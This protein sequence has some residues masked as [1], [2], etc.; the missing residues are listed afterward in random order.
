MKKSNIAKD[1]T[2]SKGTELDNKRIILCV[3]GSVAAYRAIELARLLIRHGAD[4]TCVLSAAAIR[5][6]KPE[7]FRWATG[8]T[9]ITKLTG[10][11]EHIELA[12]YN[13]SDLIIIYPA[14]ANT[15]GK[16]AGGIDDTP[17]STVL[18]VALGSGIPIVA[19]MAM[20]ASMHSNPAVRRNIKFL[21]TH[22][23]F[24]EPTITEG[25]AKAPEPN[26]VLD[27][28]IKR[29]SKYSV[30]AG[31]NALIVAGPTVEDIDPVRTISSK[32]TGKTGTL[33]AS[34]LIKRGANVKMIYGPGCTQPPAEA[35]IINTYN[36]A[37]MKRAL[38]KELKTKIDIIVMVAAVSDY[39]PIR[40][41]NTKIK[42]NK[43]FL[44]IKLK[45]ASKII[46]IIKKQKPDTFLVGFKA[47]SGISQKKLIVSTRKKMTE[48]NADL[49]IANDVNLRKSSKS[50]III[51]DKN[52]AKNSPL[53]TTSMHARLIRKEIELRL[54]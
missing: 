54:K 41:M 36:A 5:L 42:S 20:H 9:P 35:H 32:S 45:P 28:V 40:Y 30:L 38:E 6:I 1:I 44:V 23:E 51:I 2:S 26:N 34:E 47:E 16:L 33:I 7:Y 39:V 37:D 17:I 50:K 10:K 13:R 15:I 48:C 14:T 19:C 29:F 11:L 43:K 31:K 12:D 52:S 46:N 8:N 18:T 25:K 49:M 22:V 4:V 53:Q 24:V 3:S 27:T 21:R